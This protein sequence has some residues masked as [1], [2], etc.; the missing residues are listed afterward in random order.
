MKGLPPFDLSGYLASRGGRYSSG[1][2]GPQMLLTCPWCGDGGSFYVALEDHEKDGQLYPAGTYVCFRCDKKS[3][4]FIFLYAELEGISYKEARIE[5]TKRRVGHLGRVIP[6]PKPQLPVPTQQAGDI[7]PEGFKPCWDEVG[8]KYI[9]PK[10]LTQPP[11]IGRGLSKETARTY[12]LGWCD[13]GRYAHRIAIPVVCPLG[14]SFTTRAID[15]DNNLRFLAGPGCGKLL[16]GWPQA[17]QVDTLVVAEG[18]FDVMSIFQAV[19]TCPEE[20]AGAMGLLGKALRDTQIRMIKTHPAKRIILMLDGDAL[21][22]ALRQYKEL[23]PRV[24]V[25]GLLD[26]SL[27]ADHEDQL[28]PGDCALYPD[29]IIDA[30]D[31]AQHPE[32]VRIQRMREKIKLVVNRICT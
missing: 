5:L 19:Q 1:T 12:G 32:K 30:M 17:A 9:M 15:P 8:R 2:N 27:P 31:R 6:R 25:A 28:D 14:S 20:R 10:Y 24:M 13:Q 23:G 18:P 29:R 26:P 21:D 4:S 16:F 7:H 11:P 22:D 3:R